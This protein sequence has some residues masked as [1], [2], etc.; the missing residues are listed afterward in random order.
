M[1]APLDPWCRHVPDLVQ[2]GHGMGPTKPAGSGPS[3]VNLGTTVVDGWWAAPPHHQLGGLLLGHVGA[4]VEPGAGDAGA[5][6]RPRPEV[7][8]RRP[9]DLTPAR[10]SLEEHQAPGTQLW[11]TWT[12]AAWA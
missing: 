5:R 1:L 9:D 3:A 2:D 10:G 7:W 8:S 12:C 6:V 4:G 11:W